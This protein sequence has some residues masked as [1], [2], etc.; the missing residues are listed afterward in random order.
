MKM[1][2][3]GEWIQLASDAVRF[4]GRLLLARQMELA[5]AR[6]VNRWLK[7]YLGTAWSSLAL[8]A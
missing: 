3:L 6:R 8:A 5:K 2:H 4:G 1:T 7:L